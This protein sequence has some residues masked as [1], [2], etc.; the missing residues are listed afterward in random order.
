M[1]AEL[2]IKVKELNQESFRDDDQQDEQ[3]K[4]C[5][6]GCETTVSTKTSNISISYFT[7]VISS[8]FVLCHKVFKALCIDKALRQSSKKGLY[9]LIQQTE[10]PS[11]Y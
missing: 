6:D 4:D 2:F 8:S 9:P 3:N 7:H 5:A 1:P 11:S 10:A